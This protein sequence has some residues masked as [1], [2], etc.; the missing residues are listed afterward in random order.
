MCNKH[1]VQI[2]VLLASPRM[3]CVSSSMDPLPVPSRET[4]GRLF[5]IGRSCFFLITY[6][7]ATVRLS[8]SIRSSPLL[9]RRT[10]WIRTRRWQPA[11]ARR[12]RETH[13]IYADCAY[14]FIVYI[15][16]THARALH[17]PFTKECN[18][19]ICTD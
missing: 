6:P 2:R 13:T 19:R 4:R 12:V 16:L 18:H 5:R 11:Q 7:T 1:V 14:S 3:Q 10:R 17:S 9:N 15:Q 8:P